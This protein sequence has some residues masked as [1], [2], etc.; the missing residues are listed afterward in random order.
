V[1][2]RPVG[3]CRWIGTAERHRSTGLVRPLSPA[4]PGRGAPGG[5]VPGGSL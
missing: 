4:H 2:N 1:D 5:R 3:A